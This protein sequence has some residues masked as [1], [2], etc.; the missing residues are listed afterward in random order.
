MGGKRP[1]LNWVGLTGGLINRSNNEL[2]EVSKSHSSG[3][4]PIMGMERRV[5]QSVEVRS[6]S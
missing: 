2:R 1:H 4:V 3:E 6:T 5:E